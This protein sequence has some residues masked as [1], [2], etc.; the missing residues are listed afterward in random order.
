MMQ[1]EKAL[2]ICGLCLAVTPL[3]AGDLRAQQV[4]YARPP[5]TASGQAVADGQTVAPGAALTTG[6]GGMVIVELRNWPAKNNAQCTMFVIASGGNSAEVPRRT[7]AQPAACGRREQLTTINQAF[8]GLPVSA[9]VL[10]FADGPADQLHD[11]LMENEIYGRLARGRRAAQGGYTGRGRGAGS[12]G[13][14]RGRSGIAAAAATV[15]AGLAIESATYG[16][17]CGAPVGNMTSRLAEACNGSARCDYV[18][19]YQVIGDPAPGCAKDY[20]VSYRCAPGAQRE[21]RTIDGE[22]GFKSVLRIACQ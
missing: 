22:A 12:G 10:L 4:I 15:P 7:A 5:V 11:G 21:T 13:G 16:A 6:A 20:R 3:T 18:I 9:S 17:N 1:L 14:E 19:D 8:Q 2:R